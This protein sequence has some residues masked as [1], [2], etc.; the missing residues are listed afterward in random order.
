MYNNHYYLDLILEDIIKKG[1]LCDI[2]TKYATNDQL[3]NGK[4]AVLNLLTKLIAHYNTISVDQSVVF[5]VS[6]L[7]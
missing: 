2:I 3:S 7:V 1:S 4:C 6:L 5:K